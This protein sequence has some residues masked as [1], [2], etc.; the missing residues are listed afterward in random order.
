MAEEAKAKKTDN[1][2][3]NKNPKKEKAEEESLLI[4]PKV[5][6]GGPTFRGKSK[7]RGLVYE[8]D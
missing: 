3:V 5:K 2:K 6:E 7:A 1:D 8:F 4:K